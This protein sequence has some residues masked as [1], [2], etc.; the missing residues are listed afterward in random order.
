MTTAQL[1]EVS[2]YPVPNLD[3]MPEDIRQRIE[4][5]QEKAGFIPNVFITLARRPGEFRAFFDYHDA[6]M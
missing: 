4:A 6:I 5:V 1:P 3:E 2:R